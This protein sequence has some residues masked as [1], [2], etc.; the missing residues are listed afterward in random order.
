MKIGFSTLLSVAS[1]ALVTS[2]YPP[3]PPDMDQ[4][5]HPVQPPVPRNDTTVNDE[6]QRQ[7]DEAR[8]RLEAEQRM[9]QPG[10]QPGIDQPGVNPPPVNPPLVDQPGIDNP[11]PVNPTPTTY[12]YAS[13][14]PGKAGY[15]F[16]P[17]TQNQV[18]VRGIPSGTLVRD[19]NDSNP[20][21]KFR[22]P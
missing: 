21:H 8:R 7:L 17:F 5:N 15:V 22:V 4:R 20:A 16:N 6:G 3:Y 2:C 14:V 19:P 1:C 13:K 9:K 10:T 18:D 12:Q 11:A